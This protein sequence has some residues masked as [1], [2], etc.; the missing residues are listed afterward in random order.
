[1]H[2]DNPPR[3]E[4]VPVFG[5]WDGTHNGRYLENIINEIS[6]PIGSKKT[7]IMIERSSTN[8]K[9]NGCKTADDALVGV[10]QTEN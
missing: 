9:V 3:G 7:T 2:D 5:R 8:P 6:D 4:R 10:E 1:M